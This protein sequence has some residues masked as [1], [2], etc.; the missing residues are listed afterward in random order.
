MRPVANG[1]ILL[2]FIVSVVVGFSDTYH[3]EAW[4]D[5]WMRLLSESILFNQTFFKEVV[6]KKWGEIVIIT[7][8][9]NFTNYFVLFIFSSCSL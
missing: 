9:Y 4:Q 5:D 6:E 2:L 1:P 7:L 8:N 3:L